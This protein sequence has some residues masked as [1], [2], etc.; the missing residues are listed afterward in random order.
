MRVYICNYVHV[1]I[2]RIYINIYRHTYMCFFMYSLIYL[3][4]IP[5]YFYSGFDLP[6]VTGIS[7]KR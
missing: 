2:V 7:A 6:G 3:F 5:K 4:N 1:Y